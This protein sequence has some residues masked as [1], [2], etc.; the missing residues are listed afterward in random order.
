MPKSCAAALML[1]AASLQSAFA[2]DA[3]PTLQERVG[4]A[5]SLA[6]DAAQSDK[7]ALTTLWLQAHAAAKPPSMNRP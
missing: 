7:T 2:D 3:P 5:L 4:Y 1:L 6:R